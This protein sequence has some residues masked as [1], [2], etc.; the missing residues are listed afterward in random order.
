MVMSLLMLD[1]MNIHCFGLNLNLESRG[2]AA[3]T[4]A[5][6]A[7]LLLNPV[8]VWKREQPVMGERGLWKLAGPVCGA[9]AEAK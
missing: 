6:G 1:T 2:V 7:P 9:A 3:F 4:L 8:A 5:S